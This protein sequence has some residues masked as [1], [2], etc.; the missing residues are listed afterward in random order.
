MIWHCYNIALFAMAQAAECL[1]VAV[2]IRF[3][4]LSFVFFTVFAVNKNTYPHF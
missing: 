4:P 1:G 2:E 3:Y